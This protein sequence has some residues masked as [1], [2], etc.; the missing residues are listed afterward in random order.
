MPVYGVTRTYWIGTEYI[1][2][3]YG[4]LGI[5]W[6]RTGYVLAKAIFGNCVVLRSGANRDN[7]QD[8]TCTVKLGLSPC[9][10]PES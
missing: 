7:V 8:I 4:V 1:L 10:R 9:F 5:H 2:D 6:M 3:T